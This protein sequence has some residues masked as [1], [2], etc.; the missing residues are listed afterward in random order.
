[1]AHRNRLRQAGPSKRAHRVG[2]RLPISNR[3]FRNQTS[4]PPSREGVRERSLLP[5]H[6]RIRLHH[7][8]RKMQ[9]RSIQY[10]SR[11]GWLLPARLFPWPR[12]Q[13]ALLSLT[14]TLLR[15]DQSEL[16][17]RYRPRCSMCLN[18]RCL[19]RSRFELGQQAHEQTDHRQLQMDRHLPHSRS[20]QAILHLHKIPPLLRLPTHLPPVPLAI[21][22][23]HVKG[24]RT[25]RPQI[26]P[27]NRSPHRR[28]PLHGPPKLREV[29]IRR[30]LIQRQ[31]PSRIHCPTSPSRSRHRPYRTLL[32]PLPILHQ[33]QCHR[34]RSFLATRHPVHC[35]NLH[36]GRC[37]C[38]LCLPPPRST[39]E[40]FPDR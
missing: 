39:A 35:L 1:M 5:R 9:D 28:V 18:H 36:R 24:G 15:W 21:P 38:P 23:P 20:R 12:I 22:H 7:L 31:D 30:P 33:S 6:E 14:R 11:L 27:L 25:G 19:T 8:R 10:F 4:R 37:R 3:E 29:R 32:R 16:R 2:P 40:V 26:L 34:L 17:R 13:S